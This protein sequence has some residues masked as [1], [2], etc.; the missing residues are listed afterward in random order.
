MPRTCAH[1]VVGA[2]WSGR[3]HHVLLVG[4]CH[5]SMNGLMREGSERVARRLLL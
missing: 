4:R 2:G 1:D 3:E 5:V